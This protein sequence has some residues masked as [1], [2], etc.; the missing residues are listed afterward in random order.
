MFSQ[1]QP[2][3]ENPI[4]DVGIMR[5]E[6]MTV[7][8]I[9]NWEP[10]AT[11]GRFGNQSKRRLHDLQTLSP[12]VGKARSMASSYL[13]YVAVDIKLEGATLKLLMLVR[14]TIPNSA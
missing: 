6:D 9:V 11:I 7:A 2:N 14:L 13:E 12:V 3:E 1:Y 10:R 4:R 5:R 8:L